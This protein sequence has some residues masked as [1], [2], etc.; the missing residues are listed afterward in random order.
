MVW[1]LGTVA[2]LRLPFIVV[3]AWLVSLSPLVPTLRLFI[4]CINY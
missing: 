2:S 4:G 1:Y 3:L